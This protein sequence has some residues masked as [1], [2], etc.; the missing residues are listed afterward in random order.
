MGWPR[1]PSMA[2]AKRGGATGQRRRHAR[3]KEDQ[4]GAQFLASLK[5]LPAFSYS[6]HAASILP[7]LDEKKLQADGCSFFSA[8]ITSSLALASFTASDMVGCV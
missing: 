4:R 8:S 3:P 1:R 5:K 2:R 6:S 7:D